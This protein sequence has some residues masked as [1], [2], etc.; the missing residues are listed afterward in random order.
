MFADISC[1]LLAQSMQASLSLRIA[2][3]QLICPLT[4]AP[5]PHLWC[6]CKN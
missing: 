1:A 3:P 2:Q 5:C 6:S 4:K